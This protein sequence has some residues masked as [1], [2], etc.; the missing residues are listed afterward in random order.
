VALALLQAVG[1]PI[2]A[3]SA[4]RST[5]LSPTLAEHVLRGLD[6]RI[7]MILDAGPTAGGIESTVL[8]LTTSP[9]RL[10]R[11]GLISLAELEG[12]VG[13]VEPPPFISTGARP[14]PGMMARHYAPRTPLECVADGAARVS[15]LLRQ[16]SRVGWL[17]FQSPVPSASLVRV[18][19]PSETQAY[20]AGLYAALHRLDAAG[21]DRI[22]VD[23]PP[24]GDA[25]A[26][27]LDRLRRAS[28]TNAPRDQVNLD[29]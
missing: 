18:S 12:V 11:P 3:P 27:I 9:P 17:T 29:P 14:S 10:L 28:T 1:A 5:E 23:Q 16:G 22:V 19:L 13:P 25:W 7:D 6:G 24:D 15:D 20:A 26:A 21:V 2:A 4:N 8:D